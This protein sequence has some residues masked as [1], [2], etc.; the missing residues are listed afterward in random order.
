MRSRPHRIDRRNV[1]RNIRKARA[2]FGQVDTEFIVKKRQGSRSGK[3]GVDGAAPIQTAKDNMLPIVL[4]GSGDVL[5]GGIKKG[6]S[7]K[8]P[9]TENGSPRATR[10]R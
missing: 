10:I 6:Q 2:G 1:L 7:I 4:L 9:A 8:T 5:A 3:R